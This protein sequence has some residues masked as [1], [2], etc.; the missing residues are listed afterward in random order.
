[1]SSEHDYNSKILIIG[2]A[3]C[4]KSSLI[5]RYINGEYNDNYY[6]TIGV[7]FKIKYYEKNGKKIKMNIWDTAG[8][9]K[10]KSLVS[11][12]YRNS[13]IIILVFDLTNYISFRNIEKWYSDIEYICKKDNLQLFLVG[14]KADVG[15]DKYVVDEFMIKEKCL[16]Y[17]M[18]Y[19]ETSAKKN[20]NL[21]ELF[22]NISDEIYNIKVKEEQ[23]KI[24]NILEPQPENRQKLCLECNL[25]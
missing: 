22:N 25:M 10:F 13:D 20:Y 2:D 8:Q 11:S 23:E 5:N 24:L 6:N 15:K 19:Y 9:E 18:K 4:G 7:D 14:T 17:N 1:M 3:G 16:E 21:N 12:Y